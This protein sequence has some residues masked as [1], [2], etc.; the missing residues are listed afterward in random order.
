MG[1][2]QRSGQRRKDYG[3]EKV[4]YARQAANKKTEQNIE[5][6]GEIVSIFGDAILPLFLMRRNMEKLCAG[7]RE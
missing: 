5:K 7:K 3:Q 4:K 1:K 6:G 2:E